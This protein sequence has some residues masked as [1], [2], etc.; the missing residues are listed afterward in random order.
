MRYHEF[1]ERVRK[2]AGFESL[3]EAIL[4]TEATLDTLSERL[5]RTERD[6]LA[7]QLPKELKE[8]FIKGRNTERF[9][10]EDFYSRVSARA[11]VRLHRAIEQAQAVMK[12]LQEAVS[13][14]ELEDI[15]SGLPDEYSELFGKK[16]K[17]PLS[18]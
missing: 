17:G 18:P 12:V 8:Y 1:V 7:A 4:A 10:L 6:E 14:G 3:D 16:P 15:L 11:D 9:L 2:L 13:P 5:S